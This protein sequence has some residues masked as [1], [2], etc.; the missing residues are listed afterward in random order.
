MKEGKSYFALREIRAHM[1]NPVRMVALIGTG[2]I[3]AIA[4]PFGSGDVMVLVPRLAYWVVLVVVTYILGYVAYRMAVKAKPQSLALR[5]LIA[6]ALTAFSAYAVILLMNGLALQNW[7][8][9]DAALLL[10]ANTAVISFV[11]AAIF[12]IAYP[13]NIDAPDQTVA[14]PRIL[15]RLPIEKRGQLVSMSVE[16]HY[17]RIRTLSGEELV[18]MRMSD[19]MREVPQALGL[20]VH[21]SHWIAEN[22]IKS[23][24]RKGDGAVLSMTAGPDIPVSRTNVAKLY[25]AGILQKRT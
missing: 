10:F 14:R 12:Q 25:A 24:A 7:P 2:V 22:Q 20:Q 21:R 23:A 17:V 18:L 13:P 11:V 15:D 19:A 4:A 8:S 16:D 6:G 9:V 3:A 1:A 5:I